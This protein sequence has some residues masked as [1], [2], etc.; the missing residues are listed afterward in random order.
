MGRVPLALDH[1]FAFVDP[2]LAEVAPLEAAGFVVTPPHGHPGQGTAN[3]CVMFPNAYLELITVAS[4]PEAEANVLRLDRRA[5]YRSTG[6]CPFG[7]GLRGTLTDA[8]RTAFWPYEPPYRKPGGPPIWIH[9]DTS[10]V[11][12]LPLVFVME[13]WSGSPD[14]DAFRP[15]HR[16]DVAALHALAHR[17]PVRSLAGVD[18]EIPDARGWPLGIHVPG[19]RV[20]AGG[21]YRMSVLLDGE[22]LA[23]LNL[24]PHSGV[25]SGT[26]A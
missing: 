4:R 11:A 6:E 8:E 7:I 9:R 1:V 3:R 10:E 26:R 5:D 15:D 24:S 16:P 19:V 23:P 18:L 25:A 21:P 2:S 22:G 12:G 13:A 20:E 14:P 17:T